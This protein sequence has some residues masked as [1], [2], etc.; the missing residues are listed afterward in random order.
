MT[1]DPTRIY[2]LRN[3]IQPYDWGST[4]AIPSLL[5]M[6]N[7][8]AIP[9]AELWMGAHPKAPSR[10]V[11]DGAREPRAVI[12]GGEAESS[13][14]PS[15]LD[16][17]AADPERVLG[18]ACSRASQA[19]L[20]FLFKVLAASR[21]LSIQA[22]PDSRQARE[23]F[24]RE[25]ALGVPLQAPE[26]NYRDPSHKPEIICALSPFWGMC[27]FRPAGEIAEELAGLGAPSLAPL[28]EHL[29]R[30]P[31]AEGLRSFLRA[32]L[33]RD[34]A[35]AREIVG[36]AVG[37]CGRRSDPGSRAA[38]VVRIAREFPGDIGALAPLYLNLVRL[39]PG[40]AM[41]L[42]AGVLHAYLEGV[43]V[44]LMA[45]SDNVLRGGL[46]SKHVDV[47]EL[48]SILVFRGG[49]PEVLRPKAAGEAVEVYRAPTGE[50]RLS[51]VAVRA[52]A[53]LDGRDRPSLEIFI[54]VQGAGEL[55]GAQPLRFAKGDS[56]VVPQA[57][58]PY[59]ILGEAEL[60]RADVP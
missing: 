44:E 39:A 30:S 9:E 36:E 25:N 5:G 49:A 33:E 6:E 37:A 46:T 21:A 42:P 48:L 1:I 54:C 16:F 2:R 24:E 31:D 7:P 14:A 20:P 19:R 41:F 27:G 45:N 52:G 60:F 29:R 51:R 4:T 12:A 40:E 50:F 13:G 17:V 11:E 34:A 38:W 28:A 57:A 47:P 18:P 59:R 10:L 35:G 32:L 43:G 58:A 22:H 23:G 3:T 55:Q 56:F 26:R 15:L 53:V 8:A